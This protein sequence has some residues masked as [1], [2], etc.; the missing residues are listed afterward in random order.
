[1]ARGA[2]C[3]LLA[4][5]LSACVD[6]SEIGTNHLEITGGVP[7]AGYPAVFALAFDGQGGCSGTCI[8]PHVGLT[9]THC[10]DWTD[11]ASM[12]G[13]FGDTELDAETVLQVTAVATEPG[14]ADIAVVAFAEACPATIPA[15]RLALEGHV[16]EPVVMVGFGVTTEEAEDAGIKRSGTATLFSVDPA[17]VNGLEDGELA[18]SNDPAGTC[19]GDSGGPT[20]M[21]FGGVEVVVGVTSRGSLDDRGQDEPC[22]RGRSIAV[23]ADSYAAFIDDFV[24]EHDPGADPDEGE[25]DPDPDPD[26][27]PDD[28]GYTPR[29]DEPDEDDP[30]D[31]FDP[32]PERETDPG[33]PVCGTAAGTCGVAGRGGSRGPAVL[34][35]L[36]GLACLLRRRRRLGRCSSSFPSARAR[37]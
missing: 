30:S 34:L 24:A 17:E 2:A 28:D 7:E 14:G 13:L 20:F 8:T 1:M 11:A 6:L 23:R 15:N 35:G 19:N 32:A 26:R 10:V 33:A 16:D 31:P 27:D 21:T 12:T 3:T 5:A 36:A 9:A 22:G 25:P 4:M 37:G 29:D 18:T